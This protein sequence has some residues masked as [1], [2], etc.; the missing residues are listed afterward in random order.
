MIL[1]VHTGILFEPFR[2]Y[3]SASMAGLW[4]EGTQIKPCHS[5]RN[6]TLKGLCSLLETGKKKYHV[7]SWLIWG[8]PGVPSLN[9]MLVRGYKAWDF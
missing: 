9:H 8:T 1:I 2:V 3:I 4:P 7:H 5:S 6:V